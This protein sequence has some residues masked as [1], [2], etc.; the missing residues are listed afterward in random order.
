MC[1]TKT[2]LDAINTK[3]LRDKISALEFMNLL[4]NRE[5]ISAIYTWHY[6]LII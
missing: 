2:M 1:L 4:K 6:V 3:K 5:L